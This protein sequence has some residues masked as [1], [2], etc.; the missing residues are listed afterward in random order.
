M[1]SLDLI[2]SDVSNKVFLAIR[3]MLTN[4]E[5]IMLTIIL[6]LQLGILVMDTEFR[7]VD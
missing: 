1:I 3:M 6:L 7:I 5:M 2:F 4:I